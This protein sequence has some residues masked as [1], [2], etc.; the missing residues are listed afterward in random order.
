MQCP[1]CGYVMQPFENTCPRCARLGPP[2]PAPP[3]ATPQPVQPTPGTPQAFAYPPVARPFYAEYAGFWT[4]F[5]AAFLDGI[6]LSIG[7]GI[8][9]HIAR[10]MVEALL[11]A[12]GS[13]DESV[14]ATAKWT[15]I[16]LGT[17]LNWLYFTLME[18][19]SRQATLGKSALGI[20]VTDM[21]GD[22]I[23]WGRA[24]ARY[25]SKL[26][27]ALT[28]FI[29]YLMVAFTEKKQALHDMIAGTL[30]VKG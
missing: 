21:N 22:Q 19:S 13:G 2:K 20:I 17:V 7:E 5:A 16:V 14:R 28:L 29:G 10:F 6:L 23:S 9:R 3:P 12:Q 27:S 8:L 30:V 11:G 4:R 15:G 18:S 24:N 25:W 1:N 26:L